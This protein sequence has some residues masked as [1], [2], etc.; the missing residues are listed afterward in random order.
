MVIR[1]PEFIASEIADVL[2]VRLAKDLKSDARA[3]A[4]ALAQTAGNIPL[5]DIVAAQAILD[6][7]YRHESLPLPLIME[8]IELKPERHPVAPDTRAAMY[9]PG[10]GAMDV[11]FERDGSI[12]VYVRG[13]RFTIQEPGRGEAPITYGNLHSWL[14]L[15]Y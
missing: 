12:A 14:I 15:S 5:G 8:L 1:V 3:A 10:I 2:A 9:F 4:R 7:A 6:T 13:K 11:K